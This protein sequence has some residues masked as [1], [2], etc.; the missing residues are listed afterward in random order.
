M[1]HLLV[2]LKRP[3]LAIKGLFSILYETHIN[4]F[5]SRLRTLFSLFVRLVMF[6]YWFQWLYLH[7]RHVWD[8]CNDHV[9]N[10]HSLQMA[11][12]FEYL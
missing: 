10:V 8:Q 12:T 11:R 5:S 7:D 1:S 2:G 9:R 3:C 4:F 6:N